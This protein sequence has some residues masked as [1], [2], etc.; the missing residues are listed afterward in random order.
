MPK[1]YNMHADDVPGGA[2]LVDSC[3]VFGNP[4]QIGKDGNRDQV[5]SKY[6]V[7][8]LAAPDLIA[9]AKRELKGRPCLPLR[10]AAVLRRYSVEDS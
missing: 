7:D 4:Y 10:T 2:I 6:E 5:I 1:V 3:T 8:F 9:K